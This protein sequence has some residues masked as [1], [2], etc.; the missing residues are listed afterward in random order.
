[1][2][3]PSHSLKPLSPRHLLGA[4]LGQ[5]LEA[6]FIR[7]ARSAARSGPAPLTWGEVDSDALGARLEPARRALLDATG[8]A[9]GGRLLDVSAGDGTLAIEAAAAGV[10]VTALE[11]DSA[12]VD[13]GRRACAEAGVPV[14]WRSEAPVARAGFD[15]VVSC[16]AGSH[17][18]DQRRLARLMTRSAAPSGAV[19]LT[20]WK[21]LMAT[22]MQIAAPERHGRS[23]RWSRHEVAREF[24]GDFGSLS[25]RQHFMTWRFADASAALAELSAPVRSATGRRRLRDAM[26]D[27]VEM[28]GRHCESGLTLRADYVLIFAR[29]P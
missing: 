5:A 29:E 11:S 9:A 18:A 23:E 10:G 20:A 1:M 24:F 8:V 6:H 7:R 22:V 15:A 26:P 4:G 21:G 14:D 19:A 3:I 13:R 28:Y 12:L 16:F 17:S 25:V 27:L 2:A